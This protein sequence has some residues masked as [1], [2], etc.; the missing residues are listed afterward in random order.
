MIDRSTAD[1]IRAMLKPLKSRIANTVARAVI[2][3]VNDNKQLQIIQVGANAGEDIDDVENFQ[4]Y[5]FKSV[6]HV[7]A[8]VVVIFPNGDRAHPLAIA[9]DDRRYRPTGWGEGDA[10]IYNS[11]GAQVRLMGADIEVNPGA[12]GKVYLRSAG[13]TS[14][15]LVTLTEHNNHIHGT[16]TGPS[17]T[18]TVPA[19][20][21]TIIE[22]E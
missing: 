12:G 9:T 10:G 18:P 4:Q 1:Q 5:G 14:E 3:L 7:G 8:E 16:G 21:T 13:G 19:V 20:G 11:D 15:P 2:Q 6:P 17:A 22:G